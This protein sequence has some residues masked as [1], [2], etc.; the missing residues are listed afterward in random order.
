MRFTVLSVVEQ[1]ESETDYETAVDLCHGTIHNRFLQLRAEGGANLLL[2][3]ETISR[4]Y[5]SLE[6]DLERFERTGDTVYVAGENSQGRPDSSSQWLYGFLLVVPE[7]PTMSVDDWSAYHILKHN[8]G[9]N[10]METMPQAQ[11]DRLS[12][13]HDYPALLGENAM[14]RPLDSSLSFQLIGAL[15]ENVS[16]GFTVEVELSPGEEALL[17]EAGV[18]TLARKAANSQAHFENQIAENTWKAQQAIADTVKEARA[19]IGRSFRR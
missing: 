7:L 9:W 10:R 8:E 19:A 2:Q 13:F 4:T 1:Q 11:R 16:E 6:P 17:K 15:P 5:T 18:K 3:L 12:A 14:A